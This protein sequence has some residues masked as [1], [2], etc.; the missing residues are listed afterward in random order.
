MVP[1]L[2]VQNGIYNLAVWSYVGG[3]SYWQ[4]LVQIGKKLDQN[5]EDSS[6]QKERC[7]ILY[8]LVE[9]VARFVGSCNANR[10]KLKNEYPGYTTD[11]E[12]IISANKE[13][14]REN[15]YKLAKARDNKELQESLDFYLE[16]L[17]DLG[18]CFNVRKIFVHGDLNPSH[19]I[20]EVLPDGQKQTKIIDGE[21]FRIDDETTD[22]S[23]A[24]I[25]RPLG[26]NYIIRSRELPDLF[27]RYLALEHAY[28][29]KDREAITNLQAARNGAFNT[30]L[31]SR[32]QMNEEKYSNFVLSFFAQAI[33]KNINLAATRKKDDPYN[34][35]D[36]EYLR[37]LFEEVSHFNSFFNQCTNPTKVRDFFYLMGKVLHEAKYITFADDFLYQIKNGTIAG[38]IETQMPQFSSK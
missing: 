23:S 2:Y 1:G 4:K 37:E 22:I 7:Q 28:E 34:E 6:L 18:D 9:Q 27:K 10:L 33:T 13:V 16:R 26:S 24:L 3:E 31:I 11:S 21:T 17:W 38:K 35:R 25:I 30:Y 8:N 19:I 32:T 14:F 29:S 36:A 5:P 15:I 20:E 12:K